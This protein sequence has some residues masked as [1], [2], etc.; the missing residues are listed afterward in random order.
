[1]PVGWDAGVGAAIGWGVDGGATDGS[2]RE[3][4][5]SGSGLLKADGPEG[6]SCTSE[7]CLFPHILQVV[8][9][10]YSHLTECETTMDTQKHS[11]ERNL[12]GDLGMGKDCPDCVYLLL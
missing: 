5:D 7:T 3:E 12:A 2:E 4:E 11:A 1:M 10:K 9:A 8:S 6:T